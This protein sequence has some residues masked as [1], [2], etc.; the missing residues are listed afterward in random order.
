M[1]FAAA[2]AD[3]WE[4]RVSEGAPLAPVFMTILGAGGAAGFGAGASK[5]GFITGAG[6]A[7]FAGAAATG[8]AVAGAFDF[9]GSAF[10]AGA[11]FLTGAGFFL[12]TTGFLT[13]GFLAGAFLGAG[14]LAMVVGGSE[15]F[16]FPR[17]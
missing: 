12:A 9:A 17:G 16:Q 6:S 13:A 4:A 7:F 5:T 8:L 15:L 1:P 10:L 2:P 3:A 11:A 14:F